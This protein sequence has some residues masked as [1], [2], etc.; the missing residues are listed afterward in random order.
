LDGIL[1]SRL[2]GNELSEHQVAQFKTAVLVW[3]GAQYSR[4]GWVQQYHIGALRNNNQR[5]F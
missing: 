5:Q 2:A 4:R 1:A 3:L